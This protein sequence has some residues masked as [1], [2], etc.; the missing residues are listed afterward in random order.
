MENQDGADKQLSYHEYTI[1][2][3]RDSGRFTAR[4]T[5]DGALIEHDGRKS[6]AWA[7]ASCQSQDRAIHVAKTAIDDDKIR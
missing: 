3:T 4:V 7:S 6:E 2:V 5:R 1:T